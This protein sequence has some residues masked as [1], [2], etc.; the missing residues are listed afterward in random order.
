[1]V[2]R[3]P[4]TLAFGLLLAMLFLSMTSCP[5]EK[6]CL[7]CYRSKDSN[8]CKIC[9]GTVFDPKSKQCR[10]EFDNIDNCKIYETDPE[11][12]C[13]KCAF[14]FG[15]DSA[16]YACNKCLVSGC[17]VCDKDPH[18]CQAC[19]GT[20]VV[21]SN[22]REY[23]CVDD[24][25]VKNA[26]CKVN[27]KKLLD[28]KEKCGLCNDG[29]TVDERGNCVKESIRNCWFMADATCASCKYGFYESADGSC[30]ANA[31]FWGNVWMAIK[32][33]IGLA[34]VGSIFFATYIWHKN[35]PIPGPAR[36]L[37]MTN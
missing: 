35:K 14:G 10:N 34:L 16:E 31:M 29:F 13:S 20:K 4:S 8:I 18:T 6:Y 3:R 37:L 28:M 22:E 33:L 23:L 27:Y 25:A 9:E 1:M 36:E 11:K 17:A 30:K 12:R 24:P 21:S 2:S 32:F 26:P 7:K 5:D 15:L 19:F